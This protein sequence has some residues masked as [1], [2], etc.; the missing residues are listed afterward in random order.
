MGAPL[1]LSMLVT[2]DMSSVTSA[3]QGAGREVTN[4]RQTVQLTAAEMGKFSNENERA[5]AAHRKAMD[6]VRGRTQAEQE[7][8]RAVASFAGVK[9]FADNDDWGKKRGADVEAYARSL[10]ALK[11]KYN[12]L[13]AAQQQYLAQLNEI[14][15]AAKIGAITETERSNAIAATKAAFAGQITSMNGVAKSTGLAAHEVTNLTYQMN[16]VAMMLASGQSPFMLMMQ[17]GSQVSQIMGKRG[18]GEVLPALAAGITSLISPTTLFLAG[19]TAAGYAGYY[20]FKSVV[21]EARSLDD[22]L[23]SHADTVGKLKERYNT[24][25]QAASQYGRESRAALEYDLQRDTRDLNKKQVS[26]ANTL[27]NNTLGTAATL[28]DYLPKEAI[29]KYY[30]FGPIFDALVKLRKEARD[31]KP[32]FDDF[33]ETMVKVGNNPEYSNFMRTEAARLREFTKEAGKTAEALQQAK[34]AGALFNIKDVLDQASNNRPLE[35]M[36]ENQATEIQSLNARSP[37]EIAAAARARA[38]V[39]QD[40]DTPAI[41]ALRAEQAGTLALLQAQ[42]QLNDAQKERTQSLNETLASAKLDLALIGRTAA[43]TEALRMEHQL[44]AQV[45]AEAAQNN[46]A[47]DQ[48]EIARIKAMSAEL[49]RLKAQAQARD[50]LVGQN[51]RLAQAKV[52]LALTGE[53]ETVRARVMAQLEAEQDIRRRGIET[54]SAEA[55]Q[56][57]ENALAMASMTS[58]IERQADA[59]RTVQQTA[60]NS[61]DTMVDKLS[62]GDFKGA[63]DDMAKDWTKTL[64]QIGVANPLKNAVLGTNYGTAQDVGGIGGIVGKLFGGG[65]DTSGLVSSALAGQNV[66]AMNVTAASVIINGGLGSGL[67]GLLGGGAANGNM[68]SAF[69]GNA[70]PTSKSGVPAQI[71]NFFAQKGMKPHQIAAIVGHAGAESGFNPNAVGDGGAAHGLFQWNDRAPALRA[72]TGGDMSVPKQLA[73]AWH[74]MQTTENRSFR[75]LM[76]APDLRSAT[77]AFGGFERA[78]GYSASNPEGI[79]NWTGRLSGAEAALKQFGT[80]ATSATQD[81]GTF[82]GGLGDLGKGLG[83]AVQGLASGGTPGATGG[84]FLESLIG[85][86]TS[87]FKN[88]G[89]AEGG[90][91]GNGPRNAVAGVVHGG[92]VVIN[93]GVVAKPGMR[94]FLE[95]INAGTPGYAEGGYVMPRNGFAPSDGG[96][97]TAPAPQIVVN[98]YSSAD[99]RAEEESDGRGGRRTTFVIED[100]TGAALSRPGSST[101]RTMRSTYG[102]QPRLIKR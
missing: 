4:L 29:G 87:I 48:A 36:R 52:E 39:Y 70:V 45:R 7:L 27:V 96:F 67:G 43:E 5:A 83:N 6:A 77:A 99:V 11:A 40:G 47:V 31:G 86:G 75:N 32:D 21:P 90:F 26:A 102:L 9:I 79:H 60:E 97:G 23:S 1:K 101:Q 61:I 49:G 38:N 71:W 73:F 56:I 53:S 81:L 69:G 91:T 41:R 20:A 51:E 15:T 94:K 93:A 2:A 80:T 65:K 14:N 10:D 3:T 19:I 54:G 57:R 12:P 63:L 25:S 55:A 18:I 46:V 88:F 68:P 17:Q 59:W 35:R 33:R 16:D 64:L 42:K 85:I 76:A 89:F 58:A 84:G 82:G 34:I 92:E 78:Q 100:M 8:R 13:F 72:F 22:I 95:S 98:N 44:L 24:A 74:E 66:S 30:T 50:M 28:S 37:S 62:K